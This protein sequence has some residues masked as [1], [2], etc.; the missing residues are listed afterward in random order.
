MSPLR[1]TRW[2]GLA[3]IACV[4]LAACSSGAPGSAGTPPTTTAS[5]SAAPLPGSLATPSPAP[6][7]LSAVPKRVHVDS[8]AGASVWIGPAGGTVSA[9]G[10][11]G[12]GYRLVIPALAVRDPTA[13]TM[14][15]VASV[16]GLELS[17]G[18]A[19][20]V[21]LGPT[22]LKLDEP[23]T[24]TITSSKPA[25][26]GERL[27]GFDVADDG[28]TQL[29]PNAAGD[30]S[31]S[32]LVFHFSSPGAGW[33]TSEDLQRFGP[34][35]T[36]PITAD[37]RITHGISELL[38]ADAPWDAGPM[39]DAYAFIQ[40]VWG[41][42]L[43]D[44]LKNVSGDR[45]LLFALA[46]W[47]QFVFLLDLY[48]HRGDV[49]AA[50]A[51]GLQAPGPFPELTDPSTFFHAGQSLVGQRISDAIHGD[52]TL[53]EQSHDLGALANIWFWASIGDQY[54]PQPGQSWLDQA[55]ACADLDLPVANLPTS[56]G[57]GET[58]T[59]SLQFAV[60]FADGTKTNVD[61]ETKL[62]GSGVVLG[63]TGTTTA[64]AG[65]SAGTT[66]TEAVSAQAAPPFGLVVHA[67]WSLNGLVRALC[68]D[69]QEAFGQGGTPVVT[70]AL[71]TPT[72]GGVDL[73][74]LAGTYDVVLICQ[75]VQFGAGQGHVTVSG[76]NIS[77]TWS[78]TISARADGS[79]DCLS[80]AS[81][82]K[83]PTSGSFS[84]TGALGPGGA[85]NVA[86]TAWQ[87]SPCIDAAAVPPTGASFRGVAV[88]IPIGTCTLSSLFGQMGYQ[89]TRTGP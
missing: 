19:G 13:I 35:L 45:N 78:V 63:S 59:V 40:L 71:P 69:F 70:Q 80:M 2:R 18:L 11:D 55:R 6:I 67:C 66:L 76:A 47:R 72:P 14:S 68:H 20:A 9:T 57:A 23:A 36:N 46:D 84:G 7:D 29:I 5:R 52:E 83:F 89:G 28:T 81:S 44:E 64:T 41:T 75:N 21:V 24:L 50:L 77:M 58:G 54:A 4:A 82:G 88:G 51:D 87:V 48:A 32:V 85:V 17:G 16:D 1:V 42:V 3:L 74:S 33:G 49:A 43:Q 10:A 38:A 56:M 73:S 22:G 60:A 8:S 12:T 15:P 34:S 25:P 53:C 39:V 30:A 62:E 27:V 79:G 26:A 86:V 61:V 65:V 37:I 31:V